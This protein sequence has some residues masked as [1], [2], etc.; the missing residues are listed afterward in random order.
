ML[1]L[2]SPSIN[3]V[4]NQSLGGQAVYDSNAIENV[5]VLQGGWSLG[6]FDCGVLKAI[7]NNDI[8]GTSNGGINAIIGGRALSSF[9]WGVEAILKYLLAR[10]TE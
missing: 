6:A 4:K 9:P 3:N 8:T 10:G 2:Q 1:N 7:A 5:L